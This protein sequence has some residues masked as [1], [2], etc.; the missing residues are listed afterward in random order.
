MIYDIMSDEWIGSVCV[1]QSV[2]IGVQC[3][4]SVWYCLLPMVGDGCF[5]KKRE[6]LPLTRLPRINECIN[7]SMNERK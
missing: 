7:Q 1:C 4:I 2:S 5:A 6:F 3:G